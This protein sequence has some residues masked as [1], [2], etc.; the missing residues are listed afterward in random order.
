MG[1]CGNYRIIS[2]FDTNL[3]PIKPSIVSSGY[4]EAK[5]QV[6]KSYDEFYLRAS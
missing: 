3:R 2:E 5:D 6:Y 1:N 4:T